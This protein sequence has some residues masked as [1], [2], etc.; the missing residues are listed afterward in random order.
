MITTIYARLVVDDDISTYKRKYIGIRN[1]KYSNKIPPKIK[2]QHPSRPHGYFVGSP[3]TLSRKY[4]FD[5][6]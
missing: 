3:F 4:W 5:T 1:A 6:R 2:L